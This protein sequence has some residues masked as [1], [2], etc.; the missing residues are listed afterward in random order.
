MPAAPGALHPD[1]P[2]LAD[3]DSILRDGGRLDTDTR[4]KRLLFRCWQRGARKRSTSI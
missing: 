1:S 4:H 3:P 2:G